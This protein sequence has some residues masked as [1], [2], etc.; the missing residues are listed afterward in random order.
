MKQLLTGTIVV[1]VVLVGVWFCLFYLLFPLRY[2]GE[3]SAA[4]TEYGVEPALIAAVINAESGF[5]K[6]KIS[7]KNAIGLMQLLPSTAEYVTDKPCDLFNAAENIAVGTKYLAYLIDKF[8]DVNTAL[9][10]YNAGEGNVT[11]WLNEQ[12][13]K[14]LTSC[15]FAETN[16]YVAKVQKSVKFY[17]GRI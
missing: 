12:Q 17:R 11:R 15:P 5:N 1:A 7:S 8:G 16:A 6:N 4:A 2:T 14:E 9:F 13:V 3:I 10:A